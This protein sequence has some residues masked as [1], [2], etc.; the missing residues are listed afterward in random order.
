MR[1]LQASLRRVI[2]DLESLLVK[3]EDYQ[4]TARAELS[5]ASTTAK[6]L[7]REANSLMES[8]TYISQQ[9]DLYFTRVALRLENLET[10]PIIETP[11]AAERPR[12]KNARAQ[13]RSK[14]KKDRHSIREI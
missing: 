2:V 4:N 9:L 6:K 14:Q 10:F 11:E 7:R 5:G 13:R 8:R 3:K 1:T 12:P